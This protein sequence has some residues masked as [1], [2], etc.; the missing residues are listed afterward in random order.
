MKLQPLGDRL[1]V[2]VL[3]EEEQTAS[4]IV[5][6]PGE[7]V[8]SVTARDDAGNS[9]TDTLTVTLTAAFTFTDD[10]LV[11]R[12]TLV[13]AVHITELRAAIDR[14]RGDRGLAPFAWT[15]RTLVPGVTR[16]RAVHVTELRTALD[17][18][19]QA[20]RQAPPTYTDPALVA[21]RTT[22]KKVHLD[23]LRAAVLGLR[24]P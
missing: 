22:I 10:P 23:E 17:Q 6:Q 20:S 16:A 11:A 7:N 24:G 13:K 4:G 2:E 5:L 15:D 1:I 12:N 9:T 3:E 14:L 8:L 21:G 18:T 19:Y